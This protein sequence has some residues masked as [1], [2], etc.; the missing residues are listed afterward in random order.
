MEERGDTETERHGDGKT[1]VRW[2][3]EKTP[4][5]RERWVREEIDNE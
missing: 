3:A 1:L 5:L 4:L 2:D